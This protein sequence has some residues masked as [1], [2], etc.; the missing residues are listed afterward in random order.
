MAHDVKMSLT[1]QCDSNYVLTVILSHTDV[2]VNLLK[3]NL[4]FSTVFYK[5]TVQNQIG[6]NFIL[7][8]HEA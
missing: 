2:D 7:Y 4:S 3:L 5:I 6:L 8:T 1:S